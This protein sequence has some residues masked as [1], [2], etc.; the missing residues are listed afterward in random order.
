MNRLWNIN[1]EKW[2]LQSYQHWNFYCSVCAKGRCRDYIEFINAP[3]CD[4]GHPCQHHAKTITQIKD[5]LAV[6]FC[7]YIIIHLMNLTKDVQDLHMQYSASKLVPQK[8]I[9]SKHFVRLVIWESKKI[10]DH[11]GLNAILI[12]IVFNSHPSHQCYKSWSWL[13]SIIQI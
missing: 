13:K 3:D 12:L 2:H 6:S 1:I 10:A 4:R 5:H 9:S 11:F 7:N 8:M